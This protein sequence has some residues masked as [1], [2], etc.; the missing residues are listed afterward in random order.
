MPPPS[1]GNT[2]MDSML[3]MLKSLLVSLILPPGLFFVLIAVGVWLGRRRRWARWLAGVS[4]LVFI[5]L[6]LKVVAY[7]LAALFEDDWPP[8]D[9]AVAR[10][11]PAERTVIVVL[12]GGKIMGALEYPEGE[13]PDRASLRRSVFAGRLSE[14]TGLRLA[15]SGGRP[16]GGNLGEAALMKRFIERSLRRPVAFVEDRSLDTRQNAINTTR[17]LA[18]EKI[19]TIVLVTDVMHMPRAVRAFQ[20]ACAAFGMTVVAAPMHFLASAPRNINDYLPSVR[21][22]EISRDALHEFVGE[23]WYRLRRL[24]HAP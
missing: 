22:L 23:I 18:R 24:I 11:L 16:E 14:Q 1:L 7:G 6:S 3:W 21:G 8:L 17:M 20:A 9:P 13:T 19:R 5:A 15:V 10:R 2:A 12:G 4:L